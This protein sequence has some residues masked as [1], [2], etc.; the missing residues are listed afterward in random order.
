[1]YGEGKERKGEEKSG[2]LFMGRDMEYLEKG[3]EEGGE[4][5]EEVWV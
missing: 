1:M 3:F 4:G 5:K 2:E